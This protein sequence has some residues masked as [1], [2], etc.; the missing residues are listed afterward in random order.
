MPSDAPL[1]LSRSP[2]WQAALALLAALLTAEPGLALP[3]G[4]PSEFVDRMAEKWR[5]TW[6]KATTGR[7]PSLRARPARP[8]GAECRR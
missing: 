5:W 2:R 7:L 8:A 3:E 4:R 1:A 6:F